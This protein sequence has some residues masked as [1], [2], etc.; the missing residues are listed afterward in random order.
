MPIPDHPAPQH[1]PP[2]RTTAERTLLIG[3]V[4]AVVAALVLSFMLFDRFSPEPAAGPGPASEAAGTTEEAEAA[5]APTALPSVEHLFTEGNCD[6]FDL[7][8]FETLDDQPLN[9]DPSPPNGWSRTSETTGDLWCSFMLGSNGD[10][11]QTVADLS[12]SVYPDAEAAATALAGWAPEEAPEDGSLR[13]L[14][15][16]EYDGVIAEREYYGDDGMETDY[17]EIMREI[18]VTAVRDNIL[19]RADMSLEV[20]VQDLEAGLEVLMDFIDQA[21]A[22]CG[23]HIVR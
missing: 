7:A 6:F 2:R 19:M 13:D 8:K 18:E 3:L 5:E 10:T 17:D 21:Y 16:D 4:L 22:M 11:G 20:G 12:V 15:S 9:D 23:Y 1:A 14:D